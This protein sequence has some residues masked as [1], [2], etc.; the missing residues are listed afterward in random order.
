MSYKYLSCKN[1]RNSL[2]LTFQITTAAGII[3]DFFH[4]ANSINIREIGKSIIVF[5][6]Y[7]IYTIACIDMLIDN[8]QCDKDE[9]KPTQKARFMLMTPPFTSVSRANPSE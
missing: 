4:S 5:Y 9:I 2:N 6:L 1:C 3:T 8:G 7:G